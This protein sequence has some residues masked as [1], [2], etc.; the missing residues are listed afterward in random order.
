MFRFPKRLLPLRLTVICLVQDTDQRRALV[1]AVLKIMVPK[2]AGK[3]MS[4]WT[5]GYLSRK[6][7]L[8]AVS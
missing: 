7:Q 3:F 1:N 2:N 4:S 8:H 6:A 5:A